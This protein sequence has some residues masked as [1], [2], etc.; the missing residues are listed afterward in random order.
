MFQYAAARALSLRHSASLAADL[1]WFSQQF[2]VQ[3]TPR[4][5]ALPAFRLNLPE[6]DK[7]IVATFR[8]NP[9]ELR[10]VSFLRHRICFPSRFLPR[11]ITELS[12]DYWDGFRDILPPAYLD[13]YWQSE[14][15]FSDYPDI[16][17]A[18]FSM[19]S[20]SEQAAW[21]SAKIASVQDSISLHIRRGDYVNSLAT[22]KAHGID[23]ER[24]YAKALE[25]IADRI[26][27]ATIFAFSDDPRWV[28]AN[29]DFGKHKGIVVDG[30]WTAHEDMHLMSLCSHH[31][32][33]NSSFSWWGAWLS[34]SQG[35]TIAPKSWF[36]NPHIWTPDVCPA[37]WER[38]PC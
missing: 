3:T 31:I 8:L 32:I 9:T 27:A 17:R 25:W 19:L 34:T 24:Y 18:D 37:T 16:I 22:R 26:G 20:I 30:S 11:H 36:S 7:R 12:F 38:I 15:Y 10:I 35:I 14:R 5:Y 2:D 6:A 28:R 1:T 33:A 4:E 21:M 13:G 29:F 23:T